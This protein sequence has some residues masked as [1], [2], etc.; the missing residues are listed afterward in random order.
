VIHKLTVVA[1]IF[2]PLTFLTGFFGMN[3]AYLL[4]AVQGPAAFW[5]LGV[6]LQ[7]AFLGVALYLV[8]R[9]GLRRILRGDG[10]ASG[11]P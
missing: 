5:L 2:L 11:N 10:D 3:F 7:V 9:M 8:G 1:T 6:G 4:R